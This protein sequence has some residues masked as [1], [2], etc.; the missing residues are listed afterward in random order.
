[1]RVKSPCL[2]F[3]GVTNREQAT[4]VVKEAARRLGFHH[5]GISTAGFLEEEAPRLEQW[6]TG[7]RHGK[8]GYMERYFDE[9]LDPRLL[10]PGAQSVVSLLYNYYPPERPTDPDAPNLSAYAFG[11][12]YHFVIKDKLRELL[13]TVRAQVGEVNGRVFVDSAPVLERAW[14]KKS[15]LGWVG[16]NSN[17]ITRQQGSFFFIAELIIDLPLQA[18]APMRDYCGTCNRC[19]E[20]CPTGAIVE[21]YVV[22]GS[23]CISYFTIELKDALPEDMKGRFD[24]WVFGCDVCQDVCPWNRFSKPHTEPAFSLSEELKT[25]N[26]KEWEEMTED[27]FRR[28]FRNS[29][30]KRTGYRGLKRNLEFLRK[31]SGK[32]PE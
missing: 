18:D 25:M 15:G 3:F 14:A 19:M 6:L 28:V 20:A 7:N 32:L 16:K 1:M 29:A 21:P 26:R 11:A 22:D 31:P 2:V 8:M 9:R 5:C 13:D 23:R 10:V 30:V 24:D 27:V 4:Q 12:D 17:L